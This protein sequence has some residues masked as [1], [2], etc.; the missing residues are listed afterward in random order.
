MVTVADAEAVRIVNKALLA[1][2]RVVTLA[3]T[4]GVVQRKDPVE[5]TQMMYGP[6]TDVATSLE[7]AKDCVDAPLPET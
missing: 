4:I 2:F 6:A 7:S 3:L 1:K 5:D